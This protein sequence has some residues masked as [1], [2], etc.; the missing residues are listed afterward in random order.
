MSPRAGPVGELACGRNALRQASMRSS[1]IARRRSISGGFGFSPRRVRSSRKARNTSWSRLPSSL[2]LEPARGIAFEIVR[3]PHAED[4]PQEVG[5]GAAGQ[6][7]DERGRVCRP[8]FRGSSSGAPAE[9]R[10]SQTVKSSLARPQRGAAILEP[11]EV[12]RTSGAPEPGRRRRRAQPRQPPLALVER[13]VGRAERSPRRRQ[14]S[15]KSP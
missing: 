4:V 6:R 13:G 1:A 7:L 5:E 10:P 14:R 11:G 9:R 12:T 8:R 15:S 2:G 3:R